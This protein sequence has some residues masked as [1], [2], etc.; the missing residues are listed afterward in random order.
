MEVNW[1][2]RHFGIAWTMNQLNEKIYMDCSFYTQKYFDIPP[3]LEGGSCSWSRAVTWPWGIKFRN[4]DLH[5]LSILLHC[6]S[7]SSPDLELSSQEYLLLQYVNKLQSRSIYPRLKRLSCLT[8]ISSLFWMSR[9]RN[10]LARVAG[11]PLLIKI[12]RWQQWVGWDKFH[13]FQWHHI[14]SRWR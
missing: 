13:C 1:I 10:R 12:V 2:A 14:I 11:L 7:C 3:H 8:E 5:T 6:C 4:T 9:Q